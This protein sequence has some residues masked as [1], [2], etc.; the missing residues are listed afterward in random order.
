MEDTSITQDKIIFLS[1]DPAFIDSVSSIIAPESLEIDFVQDTSDLLECNFEGQY[2]AVVIDHHLK[3]ASGHEIARTLLDQDKNLPI[4]L[5]VNKGHEAVAAEALA[6][7]VQNYLIRST[8]D[9]WLTLFAGIL[10]SL[11]QT[12]K[13][14]RA[15]ADV[16]Q[17]AQESERRFQALADG[18]LEAILIINADW[19]P[20]FINEAAVS[21]YGFESKEE[22]LALPSL[23]SL[24]AQKE[25]ER[26]KEY[27][28]LRIKGEQAPNVYEYEGLKKDGSSIWLRLSAQMVE[29][30]GRPVV[31]NTI[32]DITD[33]YLMEENLRKAL[34]EAER[35]NQ[36]K[37]EFLA[38]MSHELRT[39]LNAIIGF[40]EMI[41]G[42]F[43]GKLGSHKYLE[44]AGDIHSS[45]EHLLSLID[46]ILDL[47]SIEAGEQS[48]KLEKILFTDVLDA[49]NQII[50]NSAKRKSIHYSA[51][52][53]DDLPSMFVDR[54][55][56][57]QMLLNLLSNA[58]KFT[59]ENGKV[60][61]KAGFSD[62]N[63][64]IEVCDT[65]PGIPAEFMPH[66]LEPFTRAEDDPYLA[67][68]GTGL[69]L[70]ITNS[71]AK[72]HGG[73]LEILSNP[74]VGTTVSI[75]LPRLPDQSSLAPA[76]MTGETQ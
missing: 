28:A 4:L 53:Q 42:Q 37:S 9:S 68:E 38:T 48:L 10:G 19:V 58:I 41:S 52:V 65:G 71:L 59:P 1:Q 30:D 27:R 32:I 12:A 25:H 15:V 2:E 16:Q 23:G 33:R 72:L 70:T 64:V 7:G 8:D 67:Q 55:A 36:A 75:H 14:R 61:L 3:D 22:M 57:K 50:S 35:A 18:M 6:F 74:G 63:H 34:I 21:I 40:S 45:S 56:L 31:Q 5:I 76:I 44:Y 46:D 43:F 73:K 49:C 60:I 54:R 51:Q 29:W 11:S 20:L 26:L 17:S 39:P 66:A 69:G 47:S 62:E 13:K 24:V